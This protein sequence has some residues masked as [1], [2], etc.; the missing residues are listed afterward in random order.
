MRNVSD[1]AHLRL[2][3]FHLIELVP[4]LSASDFLET[5]LNQIAR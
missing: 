2:A 1:H 4:S 3:Y 5:P